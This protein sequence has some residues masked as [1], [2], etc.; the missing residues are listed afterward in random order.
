LSGIALHG[1]VG[2]RLE[3]EAGI[4]FLQWKNRLAREIAISDKK[5]NQ[6]INKMQCKI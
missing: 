2:V 1:W 6:Q 5:N 4:I 3:F